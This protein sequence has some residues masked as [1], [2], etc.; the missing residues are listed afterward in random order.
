[1][2]RHHSEARAQCIIAKSV[3][4]LYA[5]TPDITVQYLDTFPRFYYVPFRLLVTALPSELG[6]GTY[7]TVSQHTIY[8]STCLYVTWPYI[9]LLTQDTRSHKMV[10]VKENRAIVAL[11][12]YFY[13]SSIYYFQTCVMSQ[14]IIILK[15]SQ[16]RLSFGICFC[17]QCWV[18]NQ[19]WQGSSFFSPHHLSVSSFSQTFKFPSI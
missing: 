19:A 12:Q 6:E 15:S 1:M 9:L 13:L 16:R 7:V 5:G 11:G 8:I 2:S 10:I 3:W 14:S 17:G 4:P 18:T